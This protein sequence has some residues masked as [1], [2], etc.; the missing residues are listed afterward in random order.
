M[1]LGHERID[2]RVE[3]FQSHKLSG[4][5]SERC[6]KVLADPRALA[7]CNPLVVLLHLDP[8]T[9]DPVVTLVDLRRVETPAGFAQVDFKPSRFEVCG[10]R[11][12]AFRV[13]VDGKGRQVLL[14]QRSRIHAGGRHLLAEA[15]RVGNDLGGF[16]VAGRPVELELDDGVQIAAV[17]A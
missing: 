15:E 2:R 12:A 8:E 13:A 6:G 14:A 5:G 16:Q 3:H 17:L 9:A 10:K 1:K 7:D 11:P 4:H